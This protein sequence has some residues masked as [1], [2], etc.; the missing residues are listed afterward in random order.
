M[1]YVPLKHL[2]QGMVI[3]HSVSLDSSFLPLVVADQELTQEIIN[4]LT[5]RDIP[6]IYVKSDFFIDMGTENFLNPSF[7]KNLISNIEKM[8]EYFIHKNEFSSNMEQTIKGLAD[9]LV[10]LILSKN[11]C[12]VN[13]MQLK[14]YDNY[15]YAHSMNVGVVSVLI[16]FQMGYPQST[17]SELA[18]AGFLHDIGKLDI[19]IDIINKPDKLTTEEFI[20][21]QKH[22][23]NAVARLRY[24]T[25]IMPS[26]IYGIRSHHEKYDGTGYPHGQSEDNIPL[27]GRI[28]AI[29]DIFDAITSSRSYRPAWSPHDA[30]EYMMSLA[31][32]H[33]DITLL[34]AFLKAIIIYPVGTIVELSNGHTAVVIHNTKGNSLRPVIKIFSSFEYQNLEID[35]S[36]NMEF[37]NIIIIA[38]VSDTTDLPRKLF[39]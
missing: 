24:S 36:D 3:G 18:V 9:S 8:Y 13:I 17:L 22:P 29:A 11:D 14:N 28:L 5:L 1:I 31:N 27:Y 30:I 2:R 10:N 4:K 38:L 39:C 21:I 33:F 25:H 32:T 6:G 37:L 16:G 26:V 15:T 20:E 7:K 23:E 35:L 12:L 19:S 34:N